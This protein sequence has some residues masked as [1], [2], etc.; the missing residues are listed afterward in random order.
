MWVS[1]QAVRE[2]EEPHT[3]LL[4]EFARIADR[5]ESLDADVKEN[6]TSLPWGT[7]VRAN[8]ALIESRQQQLV[9]N[10]LA[11]AL[12]VTEQEEKPQSTASER[13][14]RRRGNR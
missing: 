4:H 14:Q 9:F 7:G 5:L 8:P 6:G 13:M 1:M 2:F 10:R 3:S 12:E 11:A